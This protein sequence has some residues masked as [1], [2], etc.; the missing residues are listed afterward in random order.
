MCAK[1]SDDDD[2]DD[3]D[4]VSTVLSQD[5]QPLFSSKDKNVFEEDC[6]RNMCIEGGQMCHRHRQNSKCPPAPCCPDF[7]CAY[8]DSHHESFCVS[9][10]DSNKKT[11]IASSKKH[12]I[13]KKKDE[14]MTENCAPQEPTGCSPFRCKNPHPSSFSSKIDKKKVHVKKINVIAAAKVKVA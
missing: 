2:D 5:Q 3:D 9:M 1:D 4:D 11:E 10:S 8:V 13:S 14:L 12:A 6:D 7:Q